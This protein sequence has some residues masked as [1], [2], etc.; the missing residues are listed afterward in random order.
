MSFAIKSGPV[1][2][3]QTTGAT[4]VGKNTGPGDV[5][6]VMATKSFISDI[7]ASLKSTIEGAG[8]GAD[9]NADASRSTPKN[10]FHGNN[11]N[12]FGIRISIAIVRNVKINVKDIGE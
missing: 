7:A 12:D 6:Q 8:A 1:F 11:F 3:P 2:S 9:A 5:S 10:D 4:A